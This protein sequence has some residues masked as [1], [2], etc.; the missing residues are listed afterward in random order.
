M[1]RAM[2]QQVTKKLIKCNNIKNNTK[3]INLNDVT[4]ENIKERNP[5]WAQSPD[6][7]YRILIIG[8]SG[9]TNSLLNLIIQKPDINK[10]YFYV[11]GPYETKH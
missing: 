5:N 11:K 7:P 8:G 2:I 1:Q 10:I 4:K 6:H 9:K 3:L